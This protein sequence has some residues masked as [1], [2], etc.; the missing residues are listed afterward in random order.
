M[1]ALLI[2]LVLLCG[3]CTTQFTSPITN[4]SYTGS[5]SEEGLSIIARPPFWASACSLYEWLTD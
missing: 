2:A 4:I 5:I 1:K 3:S